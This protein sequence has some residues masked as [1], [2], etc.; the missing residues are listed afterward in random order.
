MINGPVHLKPSSFVLTL[1]PE[2]R[3]LSASVFSICI[4]LSREFIFLSVYAGVALSLILFAKIDIKEVFKRIKTVFIFL[5]MIWVLLPLTY[6]LGPFYHFGVLRLSQPGIFLC[7]IISVKSVTILAL[8]TTLVASM[9]AAAIGH[10]LHR[11][12]V[13]DK[14]VFLF[15]MAYRYIHVIHEEYQR[16]MRAAKF[17]GFRPATSLHAYK[18]Y[19]YLAGMLF[20]RAAFRANRVYHAMLCRGFTGKFYTL[21]IYPSHKGNTVF[22]A[23]TLTAGMILSGL[24]FFGR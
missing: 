8:F 15:L 5:A 17:R 3:L 12:R 2:I 10:G 16:L 14:L 18:T 24:E 19:A 11:L 23:L 7:G 4:S 13:P 6:D 21:D 1:S 9:P 20:V 22:L